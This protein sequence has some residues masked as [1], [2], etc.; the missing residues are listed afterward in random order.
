LLRAPG[1][2]ELVQYQQPHTRTA[3]ASTQK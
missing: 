2:A 1:I 3:R